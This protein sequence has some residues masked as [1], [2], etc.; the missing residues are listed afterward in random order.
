MKII[1]NRFFLIL[2]RIIDHR[3]GKTDSD[4]PDLP[5]LTMEEAILTLFVKLLLVL[6]N[7]I[8]CGFVI[9]SVIRHW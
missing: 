7:F 1:K 9:A 8:T 3:I 6:V 5:I 4:K 2:A